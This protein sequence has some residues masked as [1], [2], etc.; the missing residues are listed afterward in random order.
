MAATTSSI[1]DE[2][3]IW[4]LKAQSARHSRR[5]AFASAANAQA[6]DLLRAWRHVWA[7]IASLKGRGTPN[8]HANY[9]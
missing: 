8:R 7:R 6:R 1:E 2:G 9:A 4:S 5:A 3:T